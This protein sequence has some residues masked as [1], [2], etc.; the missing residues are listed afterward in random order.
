MPVDF[1]ASITPRRIVRTWPPY[2]VNKKL[3]ATLSIGPGETK[4]VNV[5]GTGKLIIAYFYVNSSDEYNNLEPYI[6]TDEVF[7][8]P[9]SANFA[10]WYMLYAG[11][12]KS[13]IYFG[14]HD[15]TNN[16]YC[17][18]VELPLKFEEK[19]EIGYKNTYTSTLTADVKALCEVI[20][21]VQRGVH[22]ITL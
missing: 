22:E 9:T 17:L 4:T 11:D 10:S 3:E 21:T 5:I 1:R 6:A 2:M 14:K 12:A 15:T 16:R 20:G 13:G 7:A 18:V 19:I 8:L